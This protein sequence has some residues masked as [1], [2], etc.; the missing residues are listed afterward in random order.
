M[1]FYERLNN[2]IQQ[3]GISQ[4]KLEKE[5]G[6]GNGAV[7]KWANRLPKGE[8]IILL[9]KYFNVPYEYLLDDEKN[10]LIIEAG[11]EEA[12]L[13]KMSSRIKEYALKLSELPEEKQKIVC[14]LIDALIKKED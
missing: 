1:N 13:T 7:S 2:L 9:A 11:K 8:T 12:Q 10:S 6:L 3:K 14:E 4:G 5:L